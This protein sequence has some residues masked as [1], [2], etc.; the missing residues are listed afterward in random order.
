MLFSVLHSNY[1]GCGLE[2]R[3]GQRTICRQGECILHS[4]KTQCFPCEIHWHTHLSRLE[5]KSN[6]IWVIK[7]NSRYHSPVNSVLQAKFVVFF[8]FSSHSHN[9]THYT[10][11]LLIFLFLSLFFLSTNF[12][13]SILQHTNNKTIA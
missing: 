12:S 6:R 3:M 11:L 8:F 1:G 5:L 9:T 2:D 13:L 7:H 10:F 4:P